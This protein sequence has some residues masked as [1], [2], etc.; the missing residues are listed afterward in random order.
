MLETNRYLWSGKYVVQQA[1][2]IEY[3]VGCVRYDDSVLRIKVLGK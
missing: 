3:Y 2:Y 1:K